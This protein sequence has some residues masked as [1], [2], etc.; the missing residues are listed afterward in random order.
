MVSAVPNRNN[1][2]TAT[3]LS[4][5]SLSDAIPMLGRNITG[6]LVP[7]GWTAADITLSVSLDG[8]TYADLYDVDGEIVMSAGASVFIGLNIATYMGFSFV[9]VRSGTS[10]APVNQGADRAIVLTLG[11]F[12]R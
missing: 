7:S 6:V 1:E 11:D 10:A 9:K 5:A 2:A 8:I 12:T 4:G 3:I